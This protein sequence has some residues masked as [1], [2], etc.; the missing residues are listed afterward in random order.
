MDKNM[1][2]SKLFYDTIKGVRIKR[3]EASQKR[4]RCNLNMPL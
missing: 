1:L 3:H 4:N 2:E